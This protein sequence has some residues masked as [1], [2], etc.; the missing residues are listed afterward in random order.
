MTSIIAAITVA[1][2][3]VNAHFF[4]EGILTI[5]S[6]LILSRL[7]KP[8]GV[9]KSLR[10]GTSQLCPSTDATLDHQLVGPRARHADDHPRRHIR[11]ATPI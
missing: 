11:L 8:T 1:R 5:P 9:T 6:R 7:S 2:A 3:V 4:V 10:D